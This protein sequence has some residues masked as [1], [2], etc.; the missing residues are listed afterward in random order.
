MG[1]KIP[2]VLIV[3]MQKLFFSP[4]TLEPAYSYLLAEL[5]VHLGHH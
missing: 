3:S 4:F 2:Q 5:Q 1:D